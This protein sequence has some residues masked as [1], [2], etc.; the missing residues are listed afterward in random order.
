[1]MLRRWRRRTWECDGDGNGRSDRE[2]GITLVKGDCKGLCGRGVER[3]TIRNIKQNLLFAFL[4]NAIGIP[5]AAGALYRRL[6]GC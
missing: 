5:I 4:Y 3:A 6:D 2:R 1:M